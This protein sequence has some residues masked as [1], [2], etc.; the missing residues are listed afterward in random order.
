[1]PVGAVSKVM[2][3]DNLCGSLI[4]VKSVY[5]MQGHKLCLKIEST[6]S[7]DERLVRGEKRS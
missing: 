5:D 1:M 3:S 2:A 4:C 7:V 6:N